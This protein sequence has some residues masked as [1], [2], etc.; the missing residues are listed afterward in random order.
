MKK[1]KY[2]LNT[3]E[4]VYLATAP[5]QISHYTGEHYLDHADTP[6]YSLDPVQ[7]G[8]LEGDQ[9][10]DFLIISLNLEEIDGS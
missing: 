10:Y 2:D 9:L 1:H 8:L 7:A 5:K 3:L 6:V 4:A